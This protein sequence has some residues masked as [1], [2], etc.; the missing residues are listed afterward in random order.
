MRTRD[1][2]LKKI[3]KIVDEFGGENKVKLKRELEEL[4][5]MTKRRLIGNM[6]TFVDEQ[7]LRF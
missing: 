3:Y 6:Q 7:D 2:E 5:G 4:L 1:K